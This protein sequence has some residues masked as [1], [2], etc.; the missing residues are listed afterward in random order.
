M[1]ISQKP[2]LS[3]KYSQI[4]TALPVNLLMFFHEAEVLIPIIQV[5]G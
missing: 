4:T 3:P 5:G 2:D 1:C